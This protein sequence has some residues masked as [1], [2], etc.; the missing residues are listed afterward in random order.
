MRHEHLQLPAGAVKPKT[1]EIGEGDARKQKRIPYLVDGGGDR[2]ESP[3]ECE[4][5]SFELGQRGP[6]S[7]VR[8]GPNGITQKKRR[9]GLVHWQTS[10]GSSVR[11]PGR[12]F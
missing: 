5:E 1:G 12:G 8:C 4:P 7:R 6:S 10:D 11:S 3:L 9:H 2:K